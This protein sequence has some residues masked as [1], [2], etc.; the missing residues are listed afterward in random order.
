MSEYCTLVS[1]D[2]IRIE[3]EVRGPIERVW[4]FL[5]EPDRRKT[6]LAAGG[7]EPRV[8]GAV[9]HVFRNAELTGPPR[10][11]VDEHLI[12][13]TV[14][15]WEPPRLLSYTWDDGSDV[16]F[17]LTPVGDRVRLVVTHRRIADRDGLVYY[18]AGWH[19]HLNLLVDRLADRTPPH[20]DDVMT[21]LRVEYAA[22]IGS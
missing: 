3:R 16:T 10:G 19:A 9:E 7:V 18:G 5:T 2:T 11:T 21:D 14:L 20:F 8:G 4:A 13:G 22:R 1:P 12:E 17:E 15:A 6:W